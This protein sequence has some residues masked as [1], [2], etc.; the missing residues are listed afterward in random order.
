M[1][2]TC[3]PNVIEGSLA[4]MLLLNQIELN[5]SPEGLGANVMCVSDIRR[6]GE[7]A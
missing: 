3:L 5:C 6:K 2:V 7:T 1:R 4:L